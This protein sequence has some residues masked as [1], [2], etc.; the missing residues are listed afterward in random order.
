MEN[1]TMFETIEE[2]LFNH[3]MAYIV[4]KMSVDYIYDCVNEMG[5]DK[6]IDFL[7]KNNLNYIKKEITEYEGIKELATLANNSLMQ[8]LG[9]IDHPNYNALVWLREFRVE[10]YVKL[11]FKEIAD[12]DYIAAEDND[13][14]D[15]TRNV[16]YI[17]NMKTLDVEE[18]DL[19]NWS[20]QDSA[21]LVGAKATF[22]TYKDASDAVKAVAYLFK[23]NYGSLK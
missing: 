22:M 18:V 15:K 5:V 17:V 23:H 2:K 9:S 12:L 16:L 8:K 7:N 4:H 20:A 14:E 10:S 6:A 21:E 1:K 3:G 13:K 11:L 19:S